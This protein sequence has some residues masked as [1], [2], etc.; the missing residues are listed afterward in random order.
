ML[1]GGFII[2]VASRHH[3]DHYPQPRVGDRSDIIYWS[4][5]NNYQF[6]WSYIP[7]KSLPA[8]VAITTL[9][10]LKNGVRHRNLRL[11]LAGMWAAAGDS[12]RT[13][14]QRSPASAGAYRAFQELSRRKVLRLSDVRA[15][16]K[17]NGKQLASA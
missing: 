15:I 3:V 2:R 9:K 1:D 5:R 7:F 8:Y 10:Q 16:L 12:F 4:A 11:P 14:P 17:K 13:W 6:G